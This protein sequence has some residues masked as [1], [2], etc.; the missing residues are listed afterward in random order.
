MA[1]ERGSVPARKTV[2]MPA[3]PRAER[4]RRGHLQSVQLRQEHPGELRRVRVQARGN[5]HRERGPI[6][7]F[8]S[9]SNRRLIFADLSVT[10]R[11]PVRR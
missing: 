5:H 7:G 6:P 4:H 9:G 8:N 2:E 1:P 11:A 3:I 10:V